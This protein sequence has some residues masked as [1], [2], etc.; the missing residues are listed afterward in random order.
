MFAFKNFISLLRS[1]L[2]LFCLHKVQ[3]FLFDSL[4]CHST[5][6]LQGEKSKEDTRIISIGD[7]HGKIESL[8]EILDHL[9]IAVYRYNSSSNIKCSW[10]DS[11]TSTRRTVIIQTGDIVDRGENSNLIFDC[12]ESLQSSSSVVQHVKRNEVIRLLGNHE[13]LWLS[14]DTVY[15]HP[16]DT[17]EKVEK[18]VKKLIDGILS[19]N[20]K[21]A[22]Y[23]ESFAGMKLLFSHAGLRN[24]MIQTFNNFSSD[25]FLA[26]D[27][28]EMINRVLVESCQSNSLLCNFKHP[29]FS[30][31]KDRGGTQIGGS[32]WTDFSVLQEDALL[33]TSK[34][35]IDFIQVVGHTMGKKMRYSRGL[36]SICIDLA[37]YTGLNGVGY[38]EIN[39]TGR[40]IEWIS[41]EKRI[42][43]ARD[44]TSEICD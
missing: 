19:G 23:I 29:I 16:L 15:K 5:S 2:V 27:A 41:K 9:G 38:L 1:L 32:F 22:H 40:I 30:I 13:L 6:R 43:K 7:L 8:V 12:L 31:G 21:G 17:K 37:M 18:L 42:W 24:E 14:G 26:R 35:R 36:S 39:P 44:L 10:N 20:I 33:S 34:S 3:S 28:A 4:N 11:N 25:P